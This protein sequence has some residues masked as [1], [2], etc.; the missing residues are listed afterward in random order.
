MVVVFGLAELITGTREEVAL[1]RGMTFFE[2]NAGRYALGAGVRPAKRFL[3]TT[4]ST[5]VL[6]AVT[7][8]TVVVDRNRLGFNVGLVYR[9]LLV[10]VLL[11]P[12]LPLLFVSF[13]LC[14]L[15]LLP[16]KS[17]DLDLKPFRPADGGSR[18]CCCV[19]EEDEEEEEEEAG[20]LCCAAVDPKKLRVGCDESSLP[21]GRGRLEMYDRCR[22]RPAVSVAS[23]RW[24]ASVDTGSL[25]VRLVPMALLLNGLFRCVCR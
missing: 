16:P 12:S 3:S 11:F 23:G 13:W 19:E 21:N 6:L 1:V 25:L 4:L 18:S 22:S 8:S 7:G 24:D 17:S 15:P 14:L 5:V 20:C 9:L 2:S 10:L